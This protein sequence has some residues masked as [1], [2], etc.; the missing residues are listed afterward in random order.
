MAG[1]AALGSAV[2]IGHSMRTIAII[3]T[4]LAIRINGTFEDA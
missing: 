4:H 2:G 1:R 3:R